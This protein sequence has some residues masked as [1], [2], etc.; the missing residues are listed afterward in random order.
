M[1]KRF[2][3]GLLCCATLVA[4][5]SD[6]LQDEVRTDGA[7]AH[8]APVAA[9]SVDCPPAEE[10]ITP[11]PDPCDELTY[12]NTA[13]PFFATYCAACHRLP[14]P[15]FNDIAEVTTFRSRIETRLF[16]SPSAPMPPPNAPKQPPTEEK[17]K[18]RQWLQCDPLD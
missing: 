13:A 9:A 1:I 10:P 2:R 3:I 4:C 5:G 15:T 18:L 8:E 17:Q 14:Q 12:A 7:D 6:T 16:K 11:S